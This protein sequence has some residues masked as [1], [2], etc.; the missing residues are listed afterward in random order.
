MQT[1]FVCAQSNIV[2]GKRK[3]CFYVVLII[4]TPEACLLG[5]NQLSSLS[6]ILFIFCCFFLFFMKINLSHYTHLIIE[7]LSHNN[8]LDRTDDG[9][10]EHCY[11]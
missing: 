7:V 10:C 6:A 1:Y 2:F 9:N 11:I 4:R 8:I 5:S 3:S